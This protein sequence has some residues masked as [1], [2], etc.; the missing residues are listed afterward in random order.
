MAQ[1]PAYNR[2]KDF[3]ADHGDETDNEAINTELDAVSLSISGI[4]R[5]LALIQRDDGGLCNG[6]VTKDSLDPTLKSELYAEF[7]GDVNDSVLAAQQAAVEANNAAQ[8]AVDA[9]S[10]AEAARDAAQAASGSAQAS[11]SAASGSQVAAANSATAAA[12][13]ASA[14]ATSATNSGNS[15][16]A[17]AGS[18]S[19][20]GTSA[21]NAAGSA[22]AAAGSATAAA[23]SA[24]SAGTSAGNA[25]TSAGA[26]ASSATAAGNSATL[27]QAWATQLGTP[28]AG[29]LYSARFY[30][31]QAQTHAGI[32]LYASGNIPTTNVGE[33]WVE[34]YG[35]YRWGTGVYVPNKLPAKHRNNSGVT[36]PS[37]VSVLVPVGNWRAESDFCDI[38][39]ATA[40]TKNLQASG[41]WTAG[42]GGNGIC[43][44]VR[45]INTP[46]HIFVILNP[47]TGAVDVC[48]DTDPNA[49]N[50]PAGFTQYRWVGWR[51][52]D[53]SNVIIPLLQNGM[54]FSWGYRRADA[55]P[56]SVTSSGLNL[57]LSV[58]AGRICRADISV[59]GRLAGTKIMI[60]PGGLAT[61]GVISDYTGDAGPVGA[62]T[63]TSRLTITTS[64]AGQIYLRAPVTSNWDVYTVAFE[65]ID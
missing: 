45:A 34:G 37:N 43:S 64:M 65:V 56:V 30:A 9:S 19:A 60:T 12:G 44:G 48:L 7:A 49:A 14:A 59:V 1:P 41:G 32:P 3:G 23:S 62:D 57:S 24:T 53:A 8:V 52:T 27:A 29:G 61:S 2:V 47:T 11:A 5:N 58:P 39:L 35:P 4:R 18:A 40:R 31:Q 15:A 42:E 25:S 36:T 26:A 6:I 13:S 17:A 55:S 20:A 63:P 10:S 38:I 33:I 16:T 28:V 51:V 21:G 50:R 46:Y 54:F 22:T